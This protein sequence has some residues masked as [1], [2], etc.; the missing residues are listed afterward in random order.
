MLVREKVL[1]KFVTSYCPF[2]ILNDTLNHYFCLSGNIL[3]ILLFKI[4]YFYSCLLISVD[5]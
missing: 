5:Y 4:V 3:N 2:S 1:N